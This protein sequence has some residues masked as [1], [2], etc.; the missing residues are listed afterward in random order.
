[1]NNVNIKEVSVSNEMKKKRLIIPRSKLESLLQRKT[2]E[3]LEANSGI[4][5]L[6]R[7]CDEL[8]ADV[9]LWKTKSDNLA[10]KCTRLAGLLRKYL[11]DNKSE[12]FT[13]TNVESFP[14]YSIPKTEEVAQSKKR[15]LVD[16]VESVSEKK[17]KGT[18]IE[19][20]FKEDS[21]QTTTSNAVVAGINILKVDPIISTSS[22][23]DS[24]ELRADQVTCNIPDLPNPVADSD[25]PKP[26]L[27][28]NQTE[29]GLEVLWD[30]LAGFSQEHVKEYELYYYNSSLISQ[31][32][33]K[34][35][36]IKPIPLPIKVTLAEFKSGSSYYFVVRAKSLDD[37][38]GPYSDVQKISLK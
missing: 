7:S 10:E 2:K 33:K 14:N 26:S 12:A 36:Q 35:G 24:K 28:L 17:T 29:K 25:Q 8:R 15:K 27:K 19:N 20:G 3:L 13:K 32:W 4:A 16:T 9:K 5:E 6:Q 23:S 18:Y 30:Y 11:A 21:I 34:A 1:M 38:P 37:T 31:T 22:A